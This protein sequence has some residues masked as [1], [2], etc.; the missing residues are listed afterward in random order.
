[1]RVLAAGAA[2]K[3]TVDCV[4]ASAALALG[5]RLAGTEA[6]ELPIADGGDGSLLALE[7]AGFALLERPCSDAL[8][9]PVTARIAWQEGTRTAAVEFAQAAGIA[10]LGGDPVDPWRRSS[11]GVGELI[12]HALDLSPERLIVL[13]GG[14]AT[15]D[16]GIGL[17][18]GLGVGLSGVA[19][20]LPC[21]RDLEVL[22][23]ADLSVPLRRLRGVVFEVAADVNHVLS[24]PVGSAVSFGAQK[25]FREEDIASLDRLIRHAGEVLARAAGRSLEVP[26]AGAAGGAAAALIALGAEVR[27]GADL[28][29]DLLGFDDLLAR[30]DLLLT[31]EGRADGT[32]WSGKAPGRAARRALDRGVP[33][34]LIAG[35]VGPG[36]DPG[37]GALTV[38]PAATHGGTAGPEE[39]SEAARAAVHDVLLS[40]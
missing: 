14:S 1:M 29:L 31:T 17:L 26:G 34:V 33:A 35:A 4:A 37:L 18:A 3:G 22:T 28:I 23:S 15:Q 30:S 20:S 12:G 25:G 36:G 11:R 27:S 16:A 13:V 21:A 10:R 8:G 39:I 7:G 5:A 19:G 24:G 6:S 2:L 32:T 40:P 38:R 9:R